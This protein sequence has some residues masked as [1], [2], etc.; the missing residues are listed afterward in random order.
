MTLD[1]FLANLDLNDM[2]KSL[3]FSDL[4]DDDDQEEFSSKQVSPLLKPQ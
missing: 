3:I 2:G 4:D 1:H